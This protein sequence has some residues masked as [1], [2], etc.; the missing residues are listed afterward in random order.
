MTSLPEE[1]DLILRLAQL[2]AVVG[3]GG[4]LL[5]KFSRMATKMEM[6]G[7]RQASEI[8]ELKEGQKQMQAALTGIAVQKAQLDSHSVQL[9]NLQTDIVDLRRLK[10]FI[11]HD[12]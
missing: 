6:T 10:G 2:A 5:M 11:T 1:L 12:R 7:D 3:G 9:A 8:T 4:I